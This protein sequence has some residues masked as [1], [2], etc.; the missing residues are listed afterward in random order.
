M[1]RGGNEAR[2]SS[3]SLRCGPALS[4]TRIPSDRLPIRGDIR[5][6]DVDKLMAA[7][8]NFQAVVCNFRWTAHDAPKT[9]TL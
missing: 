8:G 1:Q 9:G 6:F 2:K 3:L 5:V 4:P 7:V